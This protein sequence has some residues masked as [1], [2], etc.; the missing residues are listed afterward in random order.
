MTTLFTGPIKTRSLFTGPM[1]G[2][3]A[4][5]TILDKL[6][7]PS[8]GSWAARLLRSSYSGKCMNVRRSSDNAQQDIGFVNGVLDTASLLAFVGANNGFVTK[9]YDQSGAGLDVAQATA[10][11]QPQI[12]ASGVV[13]KINSTPAP[14]FSGNQW[15]SATASFIVN[16]MNG[17]FYAPSNVSTSESSI[18][19]LQLL[20]NG[21]LL[22]LTLTNAIGFNAPLTLVYTSANNVYT[23]PVAG[24][25]TAVSNTAGSSNIYLNGT[26][27]ASTS[28]VTQVSASGNILSVGSFGNAVQFMNGN[29]GETMLFGSS[30]SVADRQILER[31]Q[32]SFYGIS[33]V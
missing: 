32:E 22:R 23:P 17:V 21:S 24:I 26:S 7:V 13:T 4:F 10:V 14:L 1:K 15:V 27:V 28:G 29:I 31:N 12:V 5:V 6:S 33:G 25:A 9:W 3:S 18:I 16:S 8:N 30:L 2:A 11:N 19:T 20:G